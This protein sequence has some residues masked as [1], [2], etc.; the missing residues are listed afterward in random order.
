[1]WYCDLT[2]PTIAVKKAPVPFFIKPVTGMIVGRVSNDFLKQELATHFKF[3]ESQLSSAPD[4]GPFLCGSQLTVADIQMSIPVIAALT[5]S[6]ITKEEYP[7]LDSYAEKLQSTEGYQR[8]ARE[9]EELEEKPFV[10]I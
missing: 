3:L 8:A 5:L 7:R 9:V 6:I 1:L 10:A 2:C 4:S